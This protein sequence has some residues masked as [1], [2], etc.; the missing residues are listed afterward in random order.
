MPSWTCERLDDDHGYD[1]DGDKQPLQHNMDDSY[2]RMDKLCF[3]GQ[4]RLI[5]VYLGYSRCIQDDL[6]VSRMILI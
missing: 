3:V 6:D 2:L 5:Y 1:E 4:V